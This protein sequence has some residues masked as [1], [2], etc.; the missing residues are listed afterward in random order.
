MPYTS[1]GALLGLLGVAAGAVGAHALR[2]H[3]DATHLQTF[4]TAARYQLLHAL[5]LLFVG[6]HATSAPRA[7]AGFAGACF[8]AGIVL[9]SG[10]L[11]ALALSGA[12][13]WGAV[14]P[15]GGVCLM[16]GWGALA[17]AFWRRRE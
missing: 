7:G 16:L 4:E 1:I 13:A 2:G 6:T 11:Y 10:S 8:L 9:F 15:A 5:A 14:T 17:R 12:R 3:L